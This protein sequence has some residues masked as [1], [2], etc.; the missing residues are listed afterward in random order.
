MSR[1]Q[2]EWDRA[3]NVHW[4]IFR[5]GIDGLTPLLMN[6]PAK[7]RNSNKS[8]RKHI[9]SPEEEAGAGVYQNP[10]GVLCI[11]A[12][13]VRESIL[14]AARV[15]GLKIQNKPAAPRLA[16]GLMMVEE[17]FPLTRNGEPI[18]TYDRID[19]RRVM[20]QRQGVL[21]ARPV[22]DVP[23]HAEV[24]FMFDAATAAARHIAEA[25]EIS[26][27]LVGILDYRPQKG[28]IF[29]RFTVGEVWEEEV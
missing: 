2:V 24:V 11:R 16:A 6:N 25:L 18:T 15:A 13:H 29:G 23:W 19:V 1:K 20:V 26:G 10:D 7:M 28:G 4:R 12:D 21:R 27:Q 22:V 17:W 14:A 3:V 5:A 8:S 9:P